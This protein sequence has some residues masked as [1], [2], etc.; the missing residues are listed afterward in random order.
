MYNLLLHCPKV[1]NYIY[2]LLYV[3]V[4]AGHKNRFLQNLYVQIN[5]IHYCDFKFV[6]L[7]YLFILIHLLLNI[8]NVRVRHNVSS[9]IQYLL[10]TLLGTDKNSYIQ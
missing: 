3:L 5:I 4:Y 8:I 7:I 1:I 2:Y 6:I 9:K 10:A